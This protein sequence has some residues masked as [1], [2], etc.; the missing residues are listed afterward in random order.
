M[1]KIPY[2]LPEHFQDIETYLAINLYWN[3]NDVVVQ[4]AE[5]RLTNNKYQYS[6]L[7][8]ELPLCLVTVGCVKDRLVRL[9]KAVERQ[10]YSNYRVVVVDDSSATD[11]QDYLSWS[12]S[13]LKNR[14]TVVQTLQ[15][16]G[17]LAATYLCVR[18]YC[19]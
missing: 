18:K 15:K 11:T 17:A 4:E 6:R 14:I 9:L 10:N 13:T 16:M 3:A 19:P 2:R 1:N 7:P 5:Y 12:N 8:N